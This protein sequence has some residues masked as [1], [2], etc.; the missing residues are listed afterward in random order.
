MQSSTRKDIKFSIC[1]EVTT[2]KSPKIDG[3]LVKF[4]RE[5]FNEFSSICFARSKANS[6]ERRVD[7][8]FVYYVASASTN[9]KEK[10]RR[11]EEK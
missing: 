3:I 4:A 7:A 1:P 5:N 6:W 10:R 9:R 11:T 8:S 2:E